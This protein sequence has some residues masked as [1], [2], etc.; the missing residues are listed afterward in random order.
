[1]FSASWLASYVLWGEIIHRK[2]PLRVLP[3]VFAVNALA[4]LLYAMAKGP[5][6]VYAASFF[7]GIIAGGVELGR[8]NYLLDLA[9]DDKTQS[10]WGIDFTVM[11]LRGIIAPF[12]GIA[13]K[14]WLHIRVVFF[15][16]FL[17]VAASA[18]LIGLHAKWSRQTSKSA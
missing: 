2:S 12:L 7:T 5:G 10:Y 14:Q 13:L 11:G 8:M 1:V 16:S 18:C 9:S 17:M 3:F 4:P 6:L 15:L